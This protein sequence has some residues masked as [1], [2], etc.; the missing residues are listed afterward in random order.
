MAD[1][2]KGVAELQA[3]IIAERKFF[4][5]KISNSE[6][7][8]NSLREELR[9]LKRFIFA[10]KSEKWIAED[11]RQMLI[12]NEIEVIAVK[13]KKR[14]HIKGHSRKK[15]GRKALADHI[16]RVEITHDLKSEEK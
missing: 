6:N 5:E 10:H 1:L 15:A 14:I 2:P 3:I 13:E 9:Q 16:P 12:F 8:N 11:K 4:Q 7:E